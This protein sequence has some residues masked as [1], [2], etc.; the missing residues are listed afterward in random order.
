MIKE[1]LFRY[2]NKNFV[3]IKA[4]ESCKITIGTPLTKLKENKNGF[5]HDDLSKGALLH[6]FSYPKQKEVF[7]N[8]GEKLTIDSFVAYSFV[9]KCIR[10]FNNDEVVFSLS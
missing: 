5:N 4:L 6:F 10:K 8:E 2:H 3:E 1:N 9:G 7:L